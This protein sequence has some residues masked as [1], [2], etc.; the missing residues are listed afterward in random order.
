MK[1]PLQVRHAIDNF[2]PHSGPELP[3]S[4]GQGGKCQRKRTV[5]TCLNGEKSTVAQL[6]GCALLFSRYSLMKLLQP[7]YSVIL[8]K[9]LFMGIWLFLHRNI[10]KISIAMPVLTTAAAS[11]W[12]LFQAHNNG[13]FVRSSGALIYLTTM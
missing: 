12:I 11:A 3:G 2:N 10:D 13:N 6:G 1:A 9:Y 4:I 7:R 8:G 5:I